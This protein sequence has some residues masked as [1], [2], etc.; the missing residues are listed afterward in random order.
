VEVGA[1]LVVVV[2]LATGDV[3]IFGGAAT[4]GAGGGAALA[5]TRGAIGVLG[6]A[7]GALGGTT[8]ALGGTTGALGGATGALG[9]AGAGALGATGA[10]GTTGAFGGTLGAGGTSDLVLVNLISGV[11]SNETVSQDRLATENSAGAVQFLFCHFWS[12]QVRFRLPETL[13]SKESLL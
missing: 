10:F 2:G 1:T 4:T 12:S 5:G 11:R 7:T 13:A 8:G 6:G 9:A 3:A